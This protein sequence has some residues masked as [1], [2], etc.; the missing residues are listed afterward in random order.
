MPALC[1]CGWRS[2]LAILP[3]W[4]WH[5]VGATGW[6]SVCRGIAA[7]GSTRIQTATSGTTA[8]SLRMPDR[9]GG[10][11]LEPAPVGGGWEVGRGFHA[12][13]DD[14]VHADLFGVCQPSS[15][16]AN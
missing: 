3:P 10:R 6:R 1:G 8:S 15:V 12:S 5:A 13:V 2:S 14:L 4:S 9:P 7:A 16:V 11:A